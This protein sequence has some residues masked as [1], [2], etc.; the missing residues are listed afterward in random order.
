MMQQSIELALQEVTAYP[1][2]ESSLKQHRAKIDALF[3]GDS[4]E[5][6]FAALQNDESEWSAKQLKL[7]GNASPT[8]LKITHRQ[9]TEGAAKDLK[10]CLEMEF[11]MTQGCMA[12]KDF[13]EGVRAV[14]I[15]KDNTPSWSPAALEEVSDEDVAAYFA[16][17]DQEL[18]FEDFER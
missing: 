9:V 14:L 4:V 2:G 15:D 10:A 18:T 11:R 8:S 6:I 13:F 3:A 5:E 7:L 12:N 17:L 16:P 1:E